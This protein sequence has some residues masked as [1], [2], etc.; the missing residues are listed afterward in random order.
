MAR[1]VLAVAISPRRKNGTA[2]GTSPQV[3]SG[4]VV[5]RRSDL[6]AVSDSVVMLSFISVGYSL[7]CVAVESRPPA[8]SQTG[9]VKVW[10]SECVSTSPLRP[11]QLADLSGK[12]QQGTGRVGG[13]WPE[14]LNSASRNCPCHASLPFQPADVRALASLGSNWTDWSKSANLR[15]RSSRKSRLVHSARSWPSARAL[16]EILP[17]RL[18]ILPF[19]AVNC[20]PRPMLGAGKV[21]RL[22]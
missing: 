20:W 12:P 3:W 21:P 14:V 18:V 9:P 13:P 19:A 22:A 4:S 15:S 8:S 10:N 7:A 11:M 2:G 5:L 16:V 6:I 1:I 17:K